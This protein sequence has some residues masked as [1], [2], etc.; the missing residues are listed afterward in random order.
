MQSPKALF[1]VTGLAAIS[2]MA[3]CMGIIGD[4]ADSGSVIVE[5]DGAVIQVGSDGGV[6]PPTAPTLLPAR[7]RRLTGGE[8]DNTTTALLQ[9]SVHAVQTLPVDFRQG[10]YL[11]G[12]IQRGG[13]TRNANA[14]FDAT[15]TPLLQQVAVAIAQEQIPANID[16]LAP[17][18]ANATAAQQQQCA[19]NFITNFG[20][21]AYRRPVSSDELSGLLQVYAAGI[22]DQNYAGGI[23]LVLAT[24]LQSAGFLY[25]TELGD[26]VSNGTVTL[27]SYEI[28]SELSY[29]LTGGPPDAMLGQAAASDV[30][31][32]PNQRAAHA[33]RLIATPAAKTQ[34]ATFVEQWL[35]MDSPPGSNAAD[36]HTETNDF[37][38]EVVFNDDSSVNRLLSAD[39]TFVNSALGSLY[40]LS[41]TGSGFTKVQTNGQRLGLLNQGSF[42]TAY[43]YSTSSFFRTRA[44]RTPRANAAAVRPGPAAAGKLDGQHDAAGGHHDGDHASSGHAAHDRVGVQPMSHA[45]GPDR[46]RLRALRRDGGVSHDG[47]GATDRRLRHGAEQPGAAQRGRDDRTLHERCRLDHQARVQSTRRTML[48]AAL[49]RL[50]KRGERPRTGNVGPRVLVKPTRGHPEEHLNRCS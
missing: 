34:I 17:C 42:L 32:D 2:S 30:L 40:G 22:V 8:F 45:D 14:I 44:A 35:G 18:A 23:Q 15:S 41:A 13:F 49:R 47:S 48:L 21:L 10:G 31:R 3:A 11:G 1:R 29:F 7:V 43:A 25:I 5:A 50:R 26:Q 12:G 37:V 27:T 6:T 33:T 28:A 46:L 38:A 39:Y 4:N 9:T 16:T 19:S 24:I 20:T 36:M